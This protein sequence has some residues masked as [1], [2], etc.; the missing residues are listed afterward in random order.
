MIIQINNLHKMEEDQQQNTTED[1]GKLESLASFLPSLKYFGDVLEDML[2]VRDA[3]SVAHQ[4]LEYG[5]DRDLIIAEEKQ[6]LELISI[7]H[8]LISDA[9]LKL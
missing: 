5:E 2:R 4:N 3:L 7:L 1:S 6:A 8:T 9:L